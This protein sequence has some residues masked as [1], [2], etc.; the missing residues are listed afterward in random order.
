MINSFF[1]TLVVAAL[2]AV[3]AAG[4]ASGVKRV[5]DSAKRSAYFVGGGKLAQE[6]TIS[7][8]KEAQDKLAD[9]LKFDQQKLLAVVRRALEAKSLLAKTPDAALP[10]IEIVVTDVR[11]RSTFSAVM[12]GFM[13]G[14]DSV[15]GEVI[16]RDATGLELQRFSVS[17]S[18]ALG[19][20]AGGQEDSR[21]NWLYETFAQ[22]TI[23]ELTG[24]SPEK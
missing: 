3:V 20:L 12:W 17:A 13:A 15:A 14:S 6:V 11:V 18:Y 19:G 10:K 4:C 2:V 5:D 1:R 24:T 8:N 7:L 21:M 9:N 16:V 23:E 22:H